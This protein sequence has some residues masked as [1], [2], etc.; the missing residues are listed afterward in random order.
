MNF[1]S[2]HLGKLITLLCI[3]FIGILV[4]A[5]Y[6]DSK[7]PTFS[8]KK[9]ER[10]CVESHTETYTSMILVGKVMVPQVHIRT[11]CDDYKRVK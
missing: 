4:F 8:L 6:Y 9:E 3:L 2:D 7:Q 1:I 5:L 11:V 10:Q